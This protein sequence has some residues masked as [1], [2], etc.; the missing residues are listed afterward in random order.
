MKDVIV[1]LLALSLGASAYLLLMLSD[2]LLGGKRR[3]HK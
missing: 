3:E 2:W 1:I